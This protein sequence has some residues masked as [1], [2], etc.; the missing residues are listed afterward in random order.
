MLPLASTRGRGMTTWGTADA[1]ERHEPCPSCGS[2]DNLARYSD[3]HAYCFGCHYVESPNRKFVRRQQTEVKSEKPLGFPED[4]QRHI[5]PEPLKWIKGYGITD[6]E[7]E[8][9]QIGWSSSRCFLVFPYYQGG[10]LNAWQGRNFGTQGPKWYS[11]GSL[12]GLDYIVGE[13]GPTRLVFVEDIVSAIKVGRHVDACPIFG[14]YVGI[15]R[16]HRL[17][18]RGYSEFGVWL[19]HDK[20]H[21]AWQASETA[22]MLEGTKGSQLIVSKQDPKELSDDRIILLLNPLTAL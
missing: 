20:Q 22:L 6:A 17:I 16:L 18:K 7:M 11:R 5:P 1:F 13:S 9:H 14:S 12:D 4:V 19:D 8:V 21:E 10:E 15:K 2:R 3:G